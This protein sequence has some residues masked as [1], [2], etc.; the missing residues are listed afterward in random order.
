MLNAANNNEGEHEQEQDKVLNT[1][2]KTKFITRTQQKTQPIY[3]LDGS[4]PF[5][6]V[7]L[8]FPSVEFVIAHIPADHKT[9]S[10]NLAY[11]NTCT[12]IEFVYILIPGKKEEKK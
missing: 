3:T 8:Q 10:S 1:N 12:C 6:V 4:S 9:S 11:I 7:C 2:I 5:H